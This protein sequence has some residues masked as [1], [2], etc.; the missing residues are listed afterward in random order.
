MVP[1]LCDACDDLLRQLM[2]M[3]I[4]RP[5][6]DNL[7]TPYSLQ[8]FCV[9]NAHL[10]LKQMHLPTAVKALIDKFEC[11]GDQINKWRKV[12]R[13]FLIPMIEKF[14]DRFLLKSAIV[15]Y[16]PCLAPHDLINHKDMCI[17][18]F[19]KLVEK[20]YKNNSITSVEAD[21]SKNEF[22]NFLSLAQ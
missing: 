18:K 22:P 8:K 13:L 16:S 21:N 3:F 9:T 14:Q 1:F 11:L 7:E 4:L 15:R 6:F 17:L 10:R 20:L 5:T 19:E 2:N 12:S